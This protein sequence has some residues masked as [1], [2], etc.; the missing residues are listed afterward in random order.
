MENL[1]TLKR[2]LD[3]ISPEVGILTHTIK[4]PRM[5][6]DPKVV[7]FG[8]WACNTEHLHGEKFSGRSS[9][10]G[11]SWDQAML[12]TVG[13]TLE[14]YAPAF[15]NRSEA[16]ESDYNHLGKPAVKP[17]E[18]ALFHEKQLQREKFALKAFT[19]DLPLH[20]FPCHDLTSNHESWAPGQMIYMPFSIDKHPIIF[21]TS[22]GLSAHTDYY[23]AILGGIFEYIERDS[24]MIT[25]MNQLVPERIR[26]NAQL[27]QYLKEHFP[28][29][30]DF[31]LFDVK[32]D[33][34]LPAVFGICK[35]R[36]EYGEFIAVGSAARSTYGEAVLKVVQEIGQATPYFRF[37]LNEMK[38]WQ[39]RED[40]GDVYNFERH[41]I[42]Y[43]K[44]KDLWPVFDPWLQAKESREIDLYEKNDTPAGE[45]ILQLVKNLAGHGYNVLIKDTTTPDIRQAGFFSVKVLIPQLVQMSGTFKYYFNGS[46][47]LI[48]VP[49][50]M[51]FPERTYETLNPLPHPFP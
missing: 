11:Y 9:G 33:L 48:K 22:T 5:A 45:V 43:L 16:I 23:K 38:D 19:S 29:S 36:S 21:N 27:Q 2:S 25:W 41:S 40:F 14:R 24:F 1:Q 46:P 30:Y 37:L 4:L 26:I 20:W 28:P 7:N 10:C 32:Y 15:Y 18:Y 8:I 13:E 50:K 51:G 12:G 17:E 3:V 6:H 35:G 31:Y 49:P 34:G 39:P 42:L 47:R 44:R